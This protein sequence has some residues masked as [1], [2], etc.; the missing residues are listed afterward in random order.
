MAIIIVRLGKS[1]GGNLRSMGLHP[2][3]KQENRVIRK[4]APASRALL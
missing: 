2:M 3:S 4:D 1:G